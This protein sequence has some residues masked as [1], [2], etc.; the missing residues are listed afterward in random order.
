MSAG[1]RLRAGATAPALRA[2]VARTPRQAMRAAA[3]AVNRPS[4][5]YQF[6]DGLPD[7]IAL[8]AHGMMTETDPEN[9]HDY[10]DFAA[11]I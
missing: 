8:P 6:T 5:G 10:L 1:D 11:T 3:T 2:A 7:L 9:G 4:S